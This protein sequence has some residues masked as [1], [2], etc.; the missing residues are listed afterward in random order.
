LVRSYFEP[1]FGADFSDVRIHT[2]RHADAAARSIGAEAFTV[3]NHVIFRSGAYRPGPMG[4]KR[5]LA[6]ELT[7]VVQQDRTPTPAPTILPYR[8]RSS[9]NFGAADGGKWTEKPFEG[10]TKDPWVEN[11]TVTF[12]GIKKDD[13][14]DTIPTGTLTAEYYDNPHK[15]SNVNVKVVG[16]KDSAGYSDQGTHS[17]KRIEGLGYHHRAVPKAKRISG[18][19]RAGKYFKPEEAGEAS[20]NLAVFFTHGGG[21]GNQAVHYGSLDHGSLACV[22]VEDAEKMRQINY[23]SVKGMTTV[24]IKYSNSV[25]P[26]LCCARHD[27]VGY[28]VSNPCGGQDASKC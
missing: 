27:H 19:K 20:M 17:V 13:E 11:I 2:D 26:K 6:L 25:L 10:K 16:G 4:G 14:N 24:T 23:H 9:A 21:S 18:H 28:M 12:D 8:P 5:L 22:H 1:R 7:H 15:E 3:D